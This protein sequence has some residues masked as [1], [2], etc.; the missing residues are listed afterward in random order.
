MMGWKTIFIARN[1]QNLFSKPMM[2]FFLILRT[3]NDDFKM[4]FVYIKMK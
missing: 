4:E 3:Q 1:K 2:K